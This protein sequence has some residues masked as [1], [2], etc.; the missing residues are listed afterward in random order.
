MAKLKA[1]HQ[2]FIVA[3]IARY[4]KPTQVVRLVKD[5][6]GIDIERQH[7]RFYNPEQNP[8]CPTQWRQL[9]EAE[10]KNFLEDRSRIGIANK[11]YR[12]DRYG[13]LLDTILNSP[14]PNIPLALEVLKQAAQDEGG[15]FDA[16]KEDKGGAPPLPPSI[17]DAIEKVYGTP[18]L[19]PAT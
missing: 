3:A 1:E 5:E 7:V 6:Y 11:A 16:K 12:L 10:R 4:N 13:D 17:L 9:F 18:A 2:T 14:R 8:E 15:V 19:P